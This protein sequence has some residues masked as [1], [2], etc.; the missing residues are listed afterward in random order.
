MAERVVAEVVIREATLDDADALADMWLA[1]VRYHR[2]LD[3]NL[4]AAARGGEHRYVRRLFDRL[5]DPTMRV[6]IAEVNGQTVGYALGMIVDL[7]ADVF[8]QEPAGFLADI[9]VEGEYRRHGVGRRLVD[10]L[11][12]WFASQGVSHFDWQVAAQNAEGIAFWRAMGGQEVMVR[13]RA[14]VRGKA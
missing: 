5:G 4:P 6:L 14:E 12:D 3:T 1:L 9:Y 8:T 13:M 11:R 10:A 7:M 2:A